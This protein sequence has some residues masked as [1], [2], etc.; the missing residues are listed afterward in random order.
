MCARLKGFPSGGPSYLLQVLGCF[1]ICTFGA[2]SE[3]A[4]WEL[5][6]EMHEWQAGIMCVKCKRSTGALRRFDSW[7]IISCLQ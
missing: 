5:S 2:M 3:K 6:T 1:F 7:L 4:L